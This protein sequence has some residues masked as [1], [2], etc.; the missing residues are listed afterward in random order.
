[1]HDAAAAA[2][3]L[4]VEAWW[5][6]WHPRT[7]A[8][9]RARRLAARSGGSAGSRPTSPST[10][11]S[12]GNFRLDA[13]KG[14]GALYDVGC[15]AVDAAR[16]A[17]GGRP[18]AR[19]LRARATCA[20]ASTC[21][22]RRHLLRP[23]RRG[24]R[25]PLRH[26]RPRRAARRRLRRG[27]HPGPRHPGVRRQ[28]HAVPA[29]PGARDPPGAPGRARR[30]PSADRAARGARRPHAPRS[31]PPS[32]PTGSWSRRCPGAV[33]GEDVWLPTAQDSLD[34]ATVLDEV[35]ALPARAGGCAA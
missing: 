18:A 23:G 17:L 19:G 3:R 9:G 2:D 29:A 14:G 13:G 33:R 21:A 1:M 11:T 32:T 31:S 35:R 6:R 24:R 27:G 22:P 4:L 25:G 20:T 26:Q 34:I 16:W 12:T 8:R 7:R 28:G 15:Y 5:Y 10:P 30:P